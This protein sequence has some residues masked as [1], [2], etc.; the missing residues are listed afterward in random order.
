MEGFANLTFAGG[1]DTV[2]NTITAIV[3]YFSSHIQK[4]DSIR[5][6]PKL[7]PTA[8][9]EFARLITP[10]THI[11]RKCPVDTEVESYNVAANERI[12]LCWASANFDETVFDSPEEV[13]LDRRPNPHIAYGAGTHMCL[14]A[15]HARLIIRSLLKKLSE[16][17]GS[18]ELIDFDENVEREAQYQRKVGYQS[19]V[20]RLTSRATS[21]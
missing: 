19:L 3:A 10:L 7:I 2:I 18:I 15:P 14:G 11:G 21:H 17:I 8:A 13:R 4:L 12:S 6:E 5:K 16:H 9:E 20:V 1:R